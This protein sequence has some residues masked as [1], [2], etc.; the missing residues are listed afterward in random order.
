MNVIKKYL[1]AG[2]FLLITTSVF[3][4]QSISTSGGDATGNGIDDTY[5]N[6]FMLSAYPNPVTDILHLSI[7]DL[8]ISNLSFKVF[9]VNGK[10]LM[11]E[12]VTL[13]NTLISMSN[14]SSST[15]L[16]TVYKEIK[17]IKSFKI[18]KN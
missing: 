11:D 2:G 14:L 5:F 6:N 15:Y 18:I 8:E 16:L 9:D 1:F 13:S 7:E 4:Q 17:P 10:L 3:A 12:K